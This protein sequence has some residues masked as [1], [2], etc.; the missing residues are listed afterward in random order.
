M[1]SCEA[2]AQNFFPSVADSLS[3]SYWVVRSI[4]IS[5]NKITQERIILREMNIAAGDTLQAADIKKRLTFNEQ[6]IY[7]TRLFNNVELMLQPDST[8]AT[9]DA[10]LYIRVTERWFWMLLPVFELADRN[11]NVW[12]REHDYRLSRTKYGFYLINYNMRGLSE[13]LAMNFLWGYSRR[14]L[15]RYQSPAIDRRRRV[16]ITGHAAYVAE[17]EIAYTT[18]HNK[19]LNYA[20]HTFSNQ[21]W[22]GFLQMQYRR[23]LL[24]THQF[25]ISYLNNGI[26][27]EVAEKN[28]EYFGASRLQQSQLQLSYIFGNDHRDIRAYPLQGYYFKALVTVSGILK[29]ANFNALTFEAQYSR[30]KNLSKNWFW[31]G[32]IKSRLTF[33]NYLPYNMVYR[34]GFNGSFVRGYEYYVVEA[35]RYVL[36]RN[37]LKWRVVNTSFRNPLSRRVQFSKIPLQVLP[38]LYAEAAA[39]G[40]DFSYGDNPFNRSWLLGYGVGVDIYSFY[41]FTLG[42]EYS[43]NRHRDKNLLFQVNINYEL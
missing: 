9:N 26:V 31:S 32:N 27:A 3:P 42:I 33:S 20:H 34:L 25:R 37:A 2:A 5:G 17:R 13:T 29:S 19:Q 11:F 21:R 24:K 16:G 6:R 22:E 35:Q 15:L 7:N 1:Y 4:D 40:N 39:I 36:L 30:Y 38:K 28:P 8:A 14:A 23:S 12:A 43:W 18:D 41:D 10:V